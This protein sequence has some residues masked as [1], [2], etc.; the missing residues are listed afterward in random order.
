MNY[1]YKRIHIITMFIIVF[2]TQIL[3]EEFKKPQTPQELHKLFSQYFSNKNI[4]GLGSLFSENAI[5]IL[6]SDGTNVKGKEAI[7]KELLPYFEGG[8]DMNTLSTSIHIN[9]NIA[10]IKSNWEISK[11]QKGM[12]LEVMEYK[13]GGWLYIIDNPN[14][15]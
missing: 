2:S 1:I 3:A 5:F 7:M 14:G 13:N 10:L 6:D 9:G 15:F 11:D 12:A 4:D 8:S